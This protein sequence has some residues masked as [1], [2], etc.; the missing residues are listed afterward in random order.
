MFM[1]TL[2][3]EKAKLSKLALSRRSGVA[4]SVICQ[5]EKGKVY[6]FPGWRKK[7]AK[8]LDVD[9]E[10]LFTEVKNETEN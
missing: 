4:N 9:P 8:A 10:I 7:L 6:P 3:R 1:L 5:L 2:L